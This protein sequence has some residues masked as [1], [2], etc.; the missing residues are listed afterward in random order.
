[1]KDQPQQTND[2]LERATRQLDTMEQ[3]I[4]LLM[5]DISLSDLKTSERLNITIKLMSQHVRTLKLCDD[6][7]G[8]Q[9]PSASQQAFIANL[10]HALQDDSSEQNPDDKPFSCEERA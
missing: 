10:R 7:S 5:H 2:I 3:L 6:M 1:M 9:Q 8:D 4:T